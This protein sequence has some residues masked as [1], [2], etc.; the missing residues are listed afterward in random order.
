MDDNATTSSETASIEATQ[1]QTTPAAAATAATP[2]VEAGH[3]E[4]T[5]ADIRAGAVAESKRIAAI[6]QLCGGRFPEV[7]SQA[8]QEGWD[9]TRCELEILRAGRPKAPALH[10][11]DDSV[12][13]TVLEAACMLTAKLE[14]IEKHFAEPT[15]EAAGRRFR[16]G[17]GLQELLLE[18]AWANGYT[19]R[20][21]RD[22]RSVLRFAFKPE[23]EAGFS[24]VDIGGILS[25]VANKFLLEGFFSVERTWRDISSVPGTSTTSRR[26]PATAR[27][28]RT[29]TNRSPRAATSSTGRWGTRLT[30]TRPTPTA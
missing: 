10:M 14:G 11:R 1:V 7:E 6:R 28:A 8:I 13:G 4:P 25:N 26:R 22:S 5:A 9:T 12:T 2:P 30:R 18:A 3:P 15:L 23:L 17:I 16:G 27:S 21:F 24:T 29:S 19:G 20:N